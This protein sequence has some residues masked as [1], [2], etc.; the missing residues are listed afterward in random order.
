MKLNTDNCLR[1]GCYNALGGKAHLEQCLKDGICTI[2]NNECTQKFP[3][4]KQ[5][6][7]V[8]TFENCFNARLDIV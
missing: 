3:F 1:G 6:Y 8:H 4:E 7:K 2:K 5:S